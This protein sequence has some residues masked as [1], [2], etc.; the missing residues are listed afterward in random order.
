MSCESRPFCPWEDNDNLAFTILMIVYRLFIHRTC[1]MLR[2]STFLACDRIHLHPSHCSCMPTRSFHNLCSMTKPKV[3][4]MAMILA[5]CFQN[6]ACG[7]LI[8]G[9]AAISSSL[10]IASNEEGGPNS[11]S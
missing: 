11:G 6:L 5:A 2:F 1:R 7:G 9:W 10:L 4:R 8:F 3:P